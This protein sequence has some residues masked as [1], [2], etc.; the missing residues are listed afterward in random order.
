MHP[1]FIV[2][3]HGNIYRVGSLD[4]LLRL[5]K[6]FILEVESVFSN[7]VVVILGDTVKPLMNEHGSH[8]RTCGIKDSVSRKSKHRHSIPPERDR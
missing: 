3:E 1:A 8:D 7:L 4:F 6:G 5:L 2:I